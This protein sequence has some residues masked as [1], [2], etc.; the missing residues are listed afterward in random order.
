[1]GQIGK[2]APTFPTG[3]GWRSGRQ[4]DIGK[5][6]PQAA[7]G[8][9]AATSS[10]STQASRTAPRRWPPAFARGRSVGPG[11][12]APLM[13]IFHHPRPDRPGPA[14]EVRLARPEFVE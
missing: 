12:A 11:S 3:R 14:K 8:I 5:L 13:M 7:P 10:P 6:L 4:I 2:T 1:V 9:A